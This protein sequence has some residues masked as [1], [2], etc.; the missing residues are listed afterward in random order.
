MRRLV[1]L[2]AAA[3]SACM[4]AGCG[5]IADVV[6]T[7]VDAADYFT[8]PTVRLLDAARRDDQPQIDSLIAAG[9]DLDELG[10]DPDI[11]PRRV[12]IT[13]LQWAVEFGPPT[14]VGA[15]LRAGADPHLPGAGRYNAVAYSVLLDRFDAFRTIIG[16][17]EGLVEASDR[18]GGNVVH[19]AVRHRRGDALRLL[20]DRGAD[21]DSVQPLAGRTPLFTAADVLNIDHCLVLLRAGADGAHRDQRG[22]TFLPSLYTADDSIRTSSYL[23]TRGA[24]ESEMRA[25]DFPVETGR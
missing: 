18:I 4:V 17:D 9:A 25:R 14:A 20:I 8:A 12:D 3:M 23:R 5:W 10:G 7:R 13:P 2:F 11:D 15:L 22:S 6:S 1:G 24:I 19:T 21:L 16:F